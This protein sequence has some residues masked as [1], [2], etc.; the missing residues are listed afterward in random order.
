MS[1]LRSTGRQEGPI[2]QHGWG[3]RLSMMVGSYPQACWI[4]EL[5]TNLEVVSLYLVV[6]APVKSA[7]WIPS[8]CLSVLH[9]TL[10]TLP[11]CQNWAT[12]G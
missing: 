2:C 10:V 1:R 4:E 6:A 5:G 8:V 11:G 9:I 3:L 12:H 7:C